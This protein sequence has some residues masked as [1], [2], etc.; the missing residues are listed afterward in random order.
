MSED[1]FTARHR[2]LLFTVAYESSAPRPTPRIVVRRRGFGGADVDHTGGMHDARIQHA[3][4][5]FTP[6]DQRALA[7]TVKTYPITEDYDLSAAL[8]SLGIGEAIVT[9]LSEK[10]APTP[11]AWTRIRA[12]RSLMAPAPTAAITSA[13]SASPLLA[14]YG[15]AL[16]RA[17]AYEMLKGRVAV[18][19]GAQP[20]SIPTMPTGA[21]PTSSTG[22][23]PSPGPGTA[24]TVGPDGWPSLVPQAQAAPP[25]PVPAPAPRSAPEAGGGLGG[26]LD[27]PMVTSF[28]RSLGTAVGGSLG[29]SIFGTRKR[30]RR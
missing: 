19:A 8:T 5:A 28:L 7:A 27:S 30:R 18:D 26:V 24:S 2:C 17:S 9:V 22:P 14:K 1:R 23:V 4:R 21:P 29:R 20:G 3:L 15:Q 10:G 11:V 16:D 6:D 12:P 13:I 25:V